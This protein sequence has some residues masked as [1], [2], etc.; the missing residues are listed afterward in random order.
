MALP[1]N[2]MNSG[3][4]PERQL[5]EAIKS[6][7]EKS[8][9]QNTNIKRLTEIILSQNKGLTTLVRNISNTQRSTAKKEDKNANDLKRQFEKFFTMQASSKEDPKKKS[10]ET[11]SSNPA[12][13]GGLLG[14]MFGSKTKDKDD[15]GFFAGLFSRLKGGKPDDAVL[16]ELSILKSLTE[17]QNEDIAFIKSKYEDR[18]RQKDR[19]ALAAAIA[20]AINESDGGGGG[21]GFLGKLLGVGG[22]VIGG[23]LAGLKVFGRLLKN[24][25]LDVIP[26]LIKALGP[27]LL[28]AI[29]YLG[30]GL[31]NLGRSIP[32]LLSKLGASGAVLAAIPLAAGV[33]QYF[34]VEEAEERF[35]IKTKEGKVEESEAAAARSIRIQQGLG[36]EFAD[37]TI[38]QEEAQAETTRRLQAEADK[39]NPKAK[40]ALIDK[41]IRSQDPKL[42][43]AARFS[44]FMKS[45]G[46]V[47]SPLRKV[48]VKDDGGI[49]NKVAPTF[50]LKQAEEYASKIDP[51][52]R[53]IG[54]DSPEAKDLFKELKP[55]DTPPD[56][57][58]T[59]IPAGSPESIALFKEFK[60]FED[61]TIDAEKKADANL[62]AD[63]EKE[64]NT[65]VEMLKKA[66]FALDELTENIK[67]F[68]NE[69]GGLNEAAKGI[70]DF[71]DT[72]G[73]IN[74]DGQK[75]NLAPGLGG[76]VAKTL[77]ESYEI[78]KDLTSPL[79]SGVSNMINNTTNNVVEGN[80]GGGGT[81]YIPINPKNEGDSMSDYVKNL[82]KIF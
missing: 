10:E 61:P 49:F 17:K 54:K 71:L 63:I 37:P 76:S 13:R 2:P 14:N 35:D 58:V 51:R 32:S 15:K 24:L 18:A 23:L 33:A 16:G 26:S 43:K 80:S 44:E 12:K 55:F 78:T 59:E 66:G 68:F 27:M 11:K 6:Q 39:G 34:G 1:N 64:T 21:G 5:L 74:I 69:G 22:L 40:Q 52:V 48:W 28:D 82:G 75:I 65:F 7:S 38:T 4:T 31:I 25:I 45:K 42:K 53:E 73:E 36:Q 50:I 47:Y 3:N 9:I 81:S 67:D 62:E 72:M 19:E 77:K 41:D 57:R 46:Y 70:I 20:K 29:K 79:M 56:P 60:P 30:R 8:E